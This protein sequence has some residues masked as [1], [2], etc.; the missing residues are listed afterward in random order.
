MK[1]QEKK[2]GDCEKW[3]HTGGSAGKCRANSP[4]PTIMEVT[5]GKA[6]HIVWPST[7]RNERC[8]NDFKPK[9]RPV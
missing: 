8:F 9:L 7:D 1:E 4:G 6:Y 3:E 5:E 2:C